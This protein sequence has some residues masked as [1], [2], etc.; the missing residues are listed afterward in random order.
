MKN[1]TKAK[2]LTFLFMISL[3]YQKWAYGWPQSVSEQATNPITNLSQLQFE[4]DYSPTNYGSNDASNVM[5]IK[6][7]IAFDKTDWFPFEQ[8]IRI[9][10]Q[11]P[12]L[13]NSSET[14]KGTWLGDTQLFDLFVTEE[15]CWGRWGIG[16][17]AIF[18]TATS[19]E[20]GQEK[21]QIGP[22][23]GVSV[24]KFPGWQI[25]FLAQNPI[26]VGG[27]PHAS[28][29]NYLLFQ[30]FVIYHFEKNTYIISN[31]E[32]TIDWLRQAQQIPVNIGIGHTFSLINNF[33]IDLC[34][35]YECMAYQN[36]VLTAGFVP[37]NTIQLSI[38]LFEK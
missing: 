17:M 35:E 28:H 12:T 10:F 33:K 32:W 27:N 3:L 29:Q 24:L 23:L 1:L 2:A 34:L 6:P 25:G 22:A 21:W 37:Q 7:L 11:I 14:R 20:A 30:P 8:L 9:K 4:S 19:P 31:A 18:P 15:P 16:P 38:S 36:A 5:T 26:S 13:P